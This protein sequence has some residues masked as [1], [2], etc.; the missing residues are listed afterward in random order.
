M[1]QISITGKGFLFELFFLF[2]F[3]ETG[4]CYAG[5]AGLQL[6]ILLPYL[7]SSRIIGVRHCA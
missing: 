7:L 1:T 5:Q 3:S 2:F 6:V 4:F